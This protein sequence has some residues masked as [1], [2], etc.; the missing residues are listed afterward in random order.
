MSRAGMCSPGLTPYQNGW[1][2][3]RPNECLRERGR[4]FIQNIVSGHACV[5]RNRV[6]SLCALDERKEIGVRMAAHMQPITRS[7]RPL[8]LDLFDAGL[9]EDRRAHEEPLAIHP[10][11]QRGRVPSRGDEAARRCARGLLVGMEGLGIEVAP[12]RDDLGGGNVN[13]AVF[14]HFAERK[15]SK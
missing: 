15:S 11:Q 4:Y 8:P 9:F 10:Q 5:D 7:D 14:D 12:E 3:F 1:S 13:P 6:G 2:R